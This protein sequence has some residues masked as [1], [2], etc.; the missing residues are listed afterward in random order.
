MAEGIVQSLHTTAQAG[1]PMRT[2]ETVEATAGAGLA[3]DRY[4]HRRGTYSKTH[5]PD[6]EITLIEAEALDHLAREHGIELAP[7]ETRRNV[8]TRGVGLNALVGRRFRVGEVVLEGI[9]LCEPCGYLAR[10][11]GKPVFEPLTER[12]GL[13]ARIV[14]GGTLRVG[15]ALVVEAEQAAAAAQAASAR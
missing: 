2:H 14:T 7:E 13:R 1:A 15:D 9:R 6:R 4:L 3:D 8:V 5:G 12:G 10:L 11:T